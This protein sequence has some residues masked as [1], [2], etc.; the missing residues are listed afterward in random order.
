MWYTYFRKVEGG[1][2]D[3]MRKL[4]AA[5]RRGHS[6]TLRHTNDCPFDVY[7]FHSGHRRHVP[8][9]LIQQSKQPWQQLFIGR[10]CM[11]K[12][13][14]VRRLTEPSIYIRGQR[15]HLWGTSLTSF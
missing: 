4:G 7:T 6:W 10:R 12:E 8:G 13:P 3:E 1:K 15:P 14:P 9:F 5:W 11:K 2:S